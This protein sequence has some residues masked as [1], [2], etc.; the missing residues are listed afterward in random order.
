M[1]QEGK[2]R[3]MILTQNPKGG[4]GAERVVANL[5]DALKDQF[6]FLLAYPKADVSTDHDL[7]YSGRHIE[8]DLDWKGKGSSIWNK[9]SRYRKLIATIKNTIRNEEVDLVMSNLS[10][11]WHQVLILIKTFKLTKARVVLRF[12]NPVSPALKGRSKL[13]LQFI[14]KIARRVDFV[15]AN[16]EGTRQDVIE[17]LN[18]PEGK[19]KAL[20][21]PLN[22]SDIRQ[23][24][25]D[26]CEHPVFNSPNPVFVNVG[27]LDKQKNQGLLIRAFSEVLK[28]QPAELLLVGSGDKK[29]AFENMVG[30]LGI[31]ARVHF[32]GWQDNP[33]KFV[34]KSDVFVLSSDW[35]G[36]G[37]VLIEAMACGCPVISTDAL[38]APAEL[39]DRGTFG[40]VVPNHDE[41]LLAKAMLDLISDPGKR[42]HLIEQGKR[43]AEQFDLSISGARYGKLF[44]DLLSQNL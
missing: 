7:H 21:N 15:I 12:G 6:D 27:R 25:A 34:S 11:D 26:T 37:N 44:S 19:I 23:K 39:L 1:T 36:F 17:K 5:T 33:Y 32:A 13:A 9:I 35:E 31:K 14:R 43:R 10:M 2:P 29:V 30:E 42:K 4:A 38:G 24:A 8:L 20:Y 22:L 3:I 28:T 41:H 18:I 16:S 40:L